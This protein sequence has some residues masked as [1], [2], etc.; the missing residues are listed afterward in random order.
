MLAQP[1][2]IW[3]MRRFFAQCFE[4]LKCQMLAMK[5]PTFQVVTFPIG[6]QKKLVS[7][8]G[9]ASSLCFLLDRVAI[10]KDGKLK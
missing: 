9:S 1:S 5:S 7:S 10:S 6:L 3:R 4:V 8:S 2:P